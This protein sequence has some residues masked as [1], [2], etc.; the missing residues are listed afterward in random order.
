M[1]AG[2]SV[3]SGGPHTPKSERAIQSKG[4]PGITTVLEAFHRDGKGHDKRRLD[5]HNVEAVDCSLSLVS[6][7]SLNVQK[8]AVDGGVHRVVA[9]ATSITV[10]LS[11]F[12][13]S[14]SMSGNGKKY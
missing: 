5:P 1:S 11:C 9:T 2:S 6:T 10:L 3:S 7:D 13:S 4:V 8:E 14:I 12:S